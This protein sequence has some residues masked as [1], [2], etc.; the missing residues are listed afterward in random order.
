MVGGDG[1]AAWSRPP[2]HAP[3][4]FSPV[5]KTAQAPSIR[6]PIRSLSPSACLPFQA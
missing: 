5:A 2:L 6:W 3:C 4:V 1:D